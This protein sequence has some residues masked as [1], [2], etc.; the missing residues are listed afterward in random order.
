MEADLGHYHYRLMQA[1]WPVNAVFA[2]YILF[3]AVSVA[4][5]LGLYA[6]QAPDV[7]VF[8]GFVAWFGLWNLVMSQVP[9]DR[10]HDP[11]ETQAE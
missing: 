10:R 4:I 8:L 1:G 7:V 2:Y 3:S 9:R 5:G 11:R 6:I